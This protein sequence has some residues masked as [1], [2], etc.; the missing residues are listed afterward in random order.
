[1]RALVILSL[2][3]LSAV[4]VTPAFAK[5]K[6]QPSKC[7]HYSECMQDARPY[8]QKDAAS[9]P[10]ATRAT[11]YTACFARYESTCREVNCDQ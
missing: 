1:M 8:C 4:T 6:F 11:A 7:T 9:E 2:G 10:E 3:T 5:Q